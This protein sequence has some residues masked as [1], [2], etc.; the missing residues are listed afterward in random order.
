MEQTCFRY[1]VQPQMEHIKDYTHT[2]AVMF[3][4]M[5][6]YADR[7]GLDRNEVVS[8]MLHDWIVLNPVKEVTQED[9]KDWENSFGALLDSFEILDCN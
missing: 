4:D 2:I 7:N 5:I 6:D 8:E 3:E 9:Y 1:S